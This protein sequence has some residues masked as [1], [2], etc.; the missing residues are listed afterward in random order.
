MKRP[1]RRLLLRHLFYGTPV[2]G[3]AY[4]SGFEKRWLSVTRKTIP[5]AP[6]HAH[7]DGIKVGVMADF[8]HDDFGD[9]DLVR[10]AVA[11]L[12]DEAVDLVLLA[13]DY[14]SDDPSA[15]KPLCHALTDLRPRFGTF[16]VAGNHDRWHVDPDFLRD[17]LLEAGVRLLIDETVD[18]GEFCVAGMDSIWGGNPRLPYALATLPPEKPV[19]VAWHEP[20]TFLLHQDERIALQV[21][22]HTHGGQVCAPAWG[23]ILLP[24]YGKVFPYGLYREEDRHLFV[25]RGIG[26]LSI[27]ARFLCSPEVAILS[28]RVG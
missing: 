7:L 8:H 5:L 11:R 20:D 12:N 24:R 26:T 15:L 25:T 9:D 6:Q 14:V 19:V 4:G 17:G 1:T 2:V 16:A 18:L 27:P 22:G 10:R 3:L 28:L 21:S 13:G 23:P